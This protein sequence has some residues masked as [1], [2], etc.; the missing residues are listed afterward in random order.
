MQEQ[1]TEEAYS[2]SVRKCNEKN[3]FPILIALEMVLYQGIELTRNTNTFKK[4]TIKLNE[5]KRCRARR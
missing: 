1:R 4:N 2:V 5:Q 3:H